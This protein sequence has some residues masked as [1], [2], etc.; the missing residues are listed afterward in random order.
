M[1]ARSPDRVGD[2]AMASK[3]ASTCVHR[4]QGMRH[5]AATSVSPMP[6]PRRARPGEGIE[7]ARPSARR[8]RSRARRSRTRPR[9]PA[10]RL[11]V[12]VGVGKT[13][14]TG[15]DPRSARR[16]SV[17]D[18]RRRTVDAR[19]HRASSRGVD[20]QGET[21]PARHPLTGATIKRHRGRVASREAREHRI[22]EAD[23]APLRT[24]PHQHAAPLRGL[25]DR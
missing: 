6:P 12:E 2:R 18:Q 21:A 24:E 9:M 25:A 14:T 10:P 4:E 5:D 17:R 15:R 7:P 11:R 8:A 19:D 23:C 3:S 16:R 22:R 13:S 20:R 1:Y